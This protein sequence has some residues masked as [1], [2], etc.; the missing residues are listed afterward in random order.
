MKTKKVTKTFFKRS[1][2]VTLNNRLR[3]EHP[4]IQVVL[5]PRQVGKT[6]GVLWLSQQRFFYKDACYV[7]ADDEFFV[8][9]EW[10]LAQWELARQKSKKPLLIID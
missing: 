6:T 2:I 5:G 10:I 9:E 8:G 3:E 7:T 4:L 1:F